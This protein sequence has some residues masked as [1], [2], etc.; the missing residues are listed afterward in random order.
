[1]QRAYA[2][3]MLD[4]SALNKILQNTSTYELM[5]RLLDEDRIRLIVS[6]DTFN[7]LIGSDPE[8]AIVKLRKLYDLITRFDR[9]RVLMTTSL[10]V[11]FKKE[12]ASAGNLK[13]IPMISSSPRWPYFLSKLNDSEYLRVALPKQIEATK[14]N[15]DLQ[16]KLRRRGL[17]LRAVASSSNSIQIEAKRR[18]DNFDLSKELKLLKREHGKMHL[19]HSQFAR[20]VNEKDLNKFKIHKYYFGLLQLRQ[21][22]NAY[23]RYKPRDEYDHLK[24]IKEGDYYDVAIVAQSKMYDFLVTEDVDQRALCNFMSSRK[25]CDCRGISLDE[26]ANFARDP[27]L[28]CTLLEVQ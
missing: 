2:S 24:R 16:L 12:L 28:L 22:G 18:L 27:N 19:T 9:P 20:I 14:K 23:N 4:N 15:K 6:L 1:M 17:E 5:Q 11:W 26:I 13:N 8:G 10:L 3:F 21:L 7:E 25:I